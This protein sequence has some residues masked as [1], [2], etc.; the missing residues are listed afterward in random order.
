[1]WATLML[2]AVGET[3]LWCVDMWPAMGEGVLSVED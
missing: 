2:L 1:M 3:R